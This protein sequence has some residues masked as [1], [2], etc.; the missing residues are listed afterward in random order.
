MTNG[1]VTPG[2]G[3]RVTNAS[4]G[5]HLAARSNEAG[6]YTVPYLIPGVYKVEA[7]A[8]GFKKVVWE[9]ILVRVDASV[10]VDIRL[11]IGDVSDTVEV[12]GEAP[13]L[14]TAEASLGQV[15]DQRRIAEL[16]TYGGSVMMMVLLSPGDRKSVV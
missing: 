13:L 4:T 11:Q 7:E 6:I 8:P 14:S 12:K 2:V 15:V 3:I 9:N 5:V 16:P 1:E 10:N